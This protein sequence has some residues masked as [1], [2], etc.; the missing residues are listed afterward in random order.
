MPNKT[1]ERIFAD[2]ASRLLCEDWQLIDI[3]EPPDFEIRTPEQTFGLEICQVFRDPKKRIGSPEKRLEVESERAIGRLAYAY[4]NFGG[5]PIRAYFLGRIP[6]DTDE[7]AHMMVSASPSESL[8]RSTIVRDSLKVF[9]TR[10]PDEFKQ[11]SFWVSVG[12]NVGWVRKAERELLQATIDAK[13]SK[14][15]AYREKYEEIDLLIVADRTKNSAK[16]DLLLLSD[17]MASPE[18]IDQRESLRLRN[19]GFRRVLFLSYPEAIYWVS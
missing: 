12:D 19:P 3:P 9:I 18:T 2:E 8:A 16:I 4:Y 14:L 10:L 5:P 7:L 15:S 1:L 6:R 17:Q 13:E 11:Y